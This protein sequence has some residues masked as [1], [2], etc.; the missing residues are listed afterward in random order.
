MKTNL[1][2][3]NLVEKSMLLYLYIFKPYKFRRV[4]YWRNVGLQLK[5]AL[6]KVLNDSKKGNS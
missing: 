1:D 4:L 5:Y 2:S 3:L 6:E